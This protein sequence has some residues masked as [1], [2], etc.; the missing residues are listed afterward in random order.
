MDALV[1]VLLTVLPVGIVGYVLYRLVQDFLKKEERL[2]LIDKKVQNN[3]T[4]IPLK[5]QALERMIILLERMKPNN[6]VLRFY[7]PGMNVQY[8]QTELIRNLRQEMEHNVSQQLYIDSGTWKLILLAKEDVVQMIHTTAAKID[9]NDSGEKL[10]TAL[11]E[12]Y[13]SLD[14]TV[15]SEAIEMVKKELRILL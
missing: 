15:I 13:H 5:L 8:L 6:M 4:I 12:Y 11:I 14:H 7:K 1:Q 2:K 3:Q 9:N 10:S